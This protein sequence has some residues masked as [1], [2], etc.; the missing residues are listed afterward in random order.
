MQLTQV[1]TAI[2][3]RCP[4]TRLIMAVCRM[5]QVSQTAGLLTDPMV[6]RAAALEVFV[7]FLF[8]V[9]VR[10][11]LAM[12]YISGKAVRVEQLGQNEEICSETLEQVSGGKDGEQ[13]SSTRYHAGICI[14]DNLGAS[15]IKSS[16]KLDRNHHFRTTFPLR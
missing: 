7:V 5:K 3:K 8:I 9:F 14:G 6:V 15:T 1:R 11:Y 10:Q 4:A 13:S 2:Q 16:G 12:V